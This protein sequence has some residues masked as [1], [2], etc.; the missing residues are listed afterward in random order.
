MSPISPEDTRLNSALVRSYLLFVNLRVNLRAKYE[1]VP[2]IML[3]T[4]SG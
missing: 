2:G 1:T 4:L 3:L